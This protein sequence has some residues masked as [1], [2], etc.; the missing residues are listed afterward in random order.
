MPN[1]T[2]KVSQLLLGGSCLSRN[3]PQLLAFQIP[4]GYGYVV[5]TGVGSMF[6]VMW[7]AFQ[8]IRHC[9]ANFFV[10]RRSKSD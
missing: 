6:M 10:G 1:C 3:D 9:F 2:S 8:V 4:S 5:L 7:K